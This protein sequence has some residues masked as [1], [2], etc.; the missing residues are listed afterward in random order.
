MPWQVADC[1]ILTTKCCRLTHTGTVH[2]QHTAPPPRYTYANSNPLGFRQTTK[3]NGKDIGF[4]TNE[5]WVPPQ[6]DNVVCT[7]SCC[8][9]L[10]MCVGSNDT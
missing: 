9:Q 1:S 6:C 2:V 8:A 4:Q 7:G 10:G 3:R 5:W